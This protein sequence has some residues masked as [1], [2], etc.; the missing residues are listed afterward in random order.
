MA[1]NLEKARAKASDEQIVKFLIKTR[2]PNF[3]LEE[4]LGKGA[5]L[6]KI[7]EFLASKDVIQTPLPE[8]AA[9][10]GEATV[11]GDVGAPVARAPVL[12]GLGEA[13][14]TNPEMTLA[15]AGSLAAGPIT[16]G[17]SLLAAGGLAGLG[18]VAGRGARRGF[19]SF[20][21][22]E[23]PRGF[24]L[25]E[26]LALAG[27]E[28]VAFEFGGFGLSKLFGKVASPFKGSVVKQANDLSK[29]F[30]SAGGQFKPSQVSESGIIGFAENVGFEAF[31]GKGV[32]K[33]FEKKQQAAYQSLVNHVL[34]KLGTGRTPE[35]V[36]RIAQDVVTENG[37]IFKSMSSGMFDFVD[38]VIGRTPV[39]FFSP[40]KGVKSAKQFAREKIAELVELN[41]FKGSLGKFLK[42]VADLPDSMTFK[43]LQDK[44]SFMIDD[45]IAFEAAAGQSKAAGLAKKLV[46]MI[47]DDMTRAAEKLSPEGLEAFRTANKFYTNGSD[48]FQGQFI[49]GLVKE[50]KPENLVSLIRPKGI[51]DI[52]TLKAALSPKAFQEL[53]ASWLETV[54]GESIVREPGK[55]SFVSGQKLIDTVENMGGDVLR[56]LFPGVVGRKQLQTIKDVAKIGQIIQKK[57]EGGGGGLLIQ[58][59]QAGL[60]LGTAAVGDALTLTLGPA[61]LA[62]LMTSEKFLQFITKHQVTKATDRKATAAVTRLVKMALDNGVTP[63]ELNIQSSERGQ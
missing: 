6:G 55:A 58:F 1:F 48:L 59:A 51:T 8:P 42:G 35:M 16:G 22:Q 23:T 50:A 45:K 37:A 53:R 41:E 36:G 17:A 13:I 21:G 57:T 62:K 25:A 30:K 3:R 4:A 18:G 19:E 15:T 44:R 43:Q 11:P 33:Q 14:V 12:A 20:M 27:A 31:T 2:S 61:A 28:Q 29:F 46:G 24:E 56:E 47:D 32:A 26:D 63:G 54:I 5:E 10:L 9:L 60:I 7:V 49:S 34:T 39:S 52:K 38:D 40:E